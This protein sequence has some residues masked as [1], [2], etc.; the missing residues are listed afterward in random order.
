MTHTELQRERNI[1][2]TSNFCAAATIPGALV[3]LWFAWDEASQNE[4]GQ[5]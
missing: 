1:F 5:I 4:N 2:N 3:Y